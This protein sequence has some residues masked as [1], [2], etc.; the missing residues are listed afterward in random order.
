M[1]NTVLQDL[2]DYAVEKY[3]SNSDIAN[4]LICQAMIL[5]KEEKNQ[6]TDAYFSGWDTANHN[7]YCF[8]YY[9]ETYKK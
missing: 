3:G 4:D 7:D 6:I 1:K 9:Q 5:K 2:I 8:N